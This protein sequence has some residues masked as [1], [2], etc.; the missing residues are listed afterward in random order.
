[1][2]TSVLDAGRTRDPR[3]RRS[4][5]GV[6]TRLILQLRFVVDTTVP[7]TPCNENVEVN[8]I[9]HSPAQYELYDMLGV[10]GGRNSQG[11][12]AARSDFD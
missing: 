9:I 12:C 5:E 8:T 10:Y 11:L 3:K 6:Q 7:Y 1:M 4:V 2:T